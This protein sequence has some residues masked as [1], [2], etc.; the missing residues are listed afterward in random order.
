M[1][2]PDVGVVTI[3][4]GRHD[5]VRRQHASL[6]AGTHQLAHITVVAMDD[7]DIA[8]VVADGPL[9]DRAKVV[10]LPAPG[11]PL[12]R[13]R[14]IGA[15]HA[16]RRSPDGLAVFLCSGPSPSPS[17]LAR[18]RRS[19]ASTRPTEATAGRT[20]TSVSGPR[21]PGP[22]MW[23]VGAARSYHQW[24][25]VSDPPTEHLGDIIRNANLFHDR[26]GWFPMEGW[27]TAFAARGLAHHDDAQGVWRP[28]RRRGLREYDDPSLVADHDASRTEVG[29]TSRD[30]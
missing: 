1:T 14:N 19:A 5:H 12:A 9:A 28:G 22:A 7:P 3:A 18:G 6:A 27:L 20:P 8:A 4:H 10:N 30:R 26:W 21:R 25:P 29:A 23:W 24:H 16:F 11:L 17:T 13:A 15:D 2:P